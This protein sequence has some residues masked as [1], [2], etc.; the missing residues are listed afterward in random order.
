MLSAGAAERYHQALETAALVF[1]HAGVHQRHHTGQKLMHALLL[2]EIIDHGSVFT[3]EQ[4]KSLFASGI[5]Q[6]AAIENESAAIS[7]LIIW[8]AAMKRKRKY[9]HG[10]VICFGS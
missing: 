7:A 1:A 8:H 5:G 6:A 9:A 4:F 3:R 2:I 10:K